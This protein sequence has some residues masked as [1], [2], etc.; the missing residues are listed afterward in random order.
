[1]RKAI[2]FLLSIT[3]IFSACAFTISATEN[4]F[5]DV[6]EGAWYFDDVMLVT[7]KGAMTGTDDT[8]FSPESELNRAMM[9]QVLYAWEGSPEGY[10]SDFEDVDAGEWY[11]NAVSWARTNGIVAGI[12]EN[13]FGSEQLLTRE[14]MLAILYKYAANKAFVNASLINLQSYK[15]GGKVA[16][17]AVEAVKWALALDIL[18]YSDK[19][20]SSGG[21]TESTLQAKDFGASAAGLKMMASK[22][23]S[24]KTNGAPA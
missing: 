23:N 24:G 22:R 12:G 1:M 9:I 15:D 6:P 3:M 19:R 11:Y 16:P 18:H 14:Q 8:H 13:K 21:Y 10:T 2:V 4:K 7:E 17:Y 20:R 5:V